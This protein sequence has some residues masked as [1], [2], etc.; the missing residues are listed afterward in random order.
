MVIWNSGI[1]SGVKTPCKDCQERE[2][3]CHSVCED[4]ISYKKLNQDI[5]DLK[6]KEIEMFKTFDF[7][8]KAKQTR[9][10]KARIKKEMVVANRC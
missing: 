8:K 1:G 10:D 7:S 2:L 5:L 6:H 3:N 4:Y 9:S